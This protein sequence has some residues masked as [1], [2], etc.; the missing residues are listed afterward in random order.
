ME[1]EGLCRPRNSI[2]SDI[3]QWKG[4]RTARFGYLIEF[5]GQKIMMDVENVALAFRWS[6]LLDLNPS[7]LPRDNPCQMIMTAVYNAY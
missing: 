4:S 3:R 7:Q 1:K 6:G 5:Q 2:C